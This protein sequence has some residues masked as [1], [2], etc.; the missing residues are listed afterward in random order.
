MRLGIWT[1]LPHTIQA[2]P[3][4]EEGVRQVKTRGDGG[5]DKSFEFA[6]DVVLKGESY[7]FDITL[8]AERLLGP[9]LEAWMLTAALAAS[10]GIPTGIS[11]LV[12]EF[13]PAPGCRLP[14]WRLTWQ[15]TSWWRGSK[16]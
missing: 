2:E 11:H 9:D 15:S 3:V 16:P 7:G 1:P 12:P 4:M 6:L 13:T 10:P 14:G 5:P 8:I